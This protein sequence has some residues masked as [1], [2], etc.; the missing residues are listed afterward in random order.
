MIPLIIALYICCGFMTAML[1]KL[2]IWPDHWDLTLMLIIMLIWPAIIAYAF[3]EGLS[4]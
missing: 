2:S 3:I 1:A 4:N